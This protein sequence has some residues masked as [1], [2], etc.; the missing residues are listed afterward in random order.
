M[1]EACENLH[2][3]IIFITEP[4]VKWTIVTKD[5]IHR[6]MKKL[7]RNAELFVAD[8]TYHILIKN[9]WL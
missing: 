8:S 3:D 6:K 1:I 4:N 9:T 2:L 7:S 5:R